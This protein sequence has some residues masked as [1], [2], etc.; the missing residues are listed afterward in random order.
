MGAG[1]KRDH[2][3]HAKITSQNMDE[4]N[5]NYDFYHQEEAK[6]KQADLLIPPD[7]DPDFKN[8]SKSDLFQLTHSH[9]SSE[10]ERRADGSGK[11]R[12]STS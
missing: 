3:N 8:I 5:E 11:R 7:D 6:A 12:N 10:L 2:Y 4:D 9:H 1:L